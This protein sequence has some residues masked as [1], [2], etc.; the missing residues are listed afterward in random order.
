MR[1]GLPVQ[2]ASKTPLESAAS[3]DRFLTNTNKRSA[4]ANYL[5]GCGQ[6]KQRKQ[7]LTNSAIDL[8]GNTIC[9][10][11]ILCT[12][13]AFGK[14]VPELI[15]RELSA[16]VGAK[17]RDDVL[18]R[19]GFGARLEALESLEDVTLAC[20]AQ[21]KKR[22]WRSQSSDN[23]CATERELTARLWARVQAVLLTVDW[24]PDCRKG[25]QKGRQEVRCVARIG[26]CAKQ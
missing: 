24:Q 1:T 25:S 13:P 7:A 26:R 19:L 11:G 21:L 12:D 22:Q 5:S 2:T 14:E 10:W 15:R 23:K 20:Q 16:I 3:G 4:F 18:A 17:L 9:S 8:L 6:V